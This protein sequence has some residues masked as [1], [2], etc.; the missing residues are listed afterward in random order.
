[1]CH[2]KQFV[3]LIAKHFPSILVLNIQKEEEGGAFISILK[4]LSSIQQTIATVCIFRNVVFPQHRAKNQSLAQMLNQPM[5]FWEPKDV[6]TENKPSRCIDISIYIAFYDI[7][8]V[9]AKK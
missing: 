3:L 1:M 4:M 8:R 7:R 9:T 2:L 6:D 5:L